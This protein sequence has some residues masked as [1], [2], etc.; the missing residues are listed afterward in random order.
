MKKL[1]FILSVLLIVGCMQKSPYSPHMLAIEQS[2]ESNADTALRQLD[3]WKDSMTTR[4]DSMLYVLV[5]SETARSAGMTF[6]DESWI[7]PAVGFFDSI[8]DRQRTARAMLM[9]ALCYYDEG[10]YDNAALWLMRTREQD[11]GGEPQLQQRLYIALGDLNDMTGRMEEKI[12]DYNTAYNAARTCGNNGTEIHALYKLAIAY[13]EK[14]A[15]DSLRMITSRMRETGGKSDEAQACAH[16]A[17]GMYAILNHD[18]TTALNELIRAQP[19]E[20]EC[21]AASLA[22]EIIEIR[23]NTEAARNMWLMASN[24][25]N[26]DIAINALTHL[27]DDNGIERSEAYTL[28]LSRL[29]NDLYADKPSAEVMSKVVEV[30]RQFDEKANEEQ[31]QHKITLLITLASILVL[32][33]IISAIAIV[34]RIRLK[35]RAKVSWNIERE[36]LD[37]TVSRH[38]HKIAA[39]GRSAQ[40]DDWTAL[41]DL[42]A[43]HDTALVGLLAKNKNLTETDKHLIQLIRLRFQP[44]EIAVLMQM[45]PQRVTNVRSRMLSRLFNS[46][47]GAKDFDR[48][49]R[50]L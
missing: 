17:A 46:K 35:R 14:R 1:P 28:S 12:K 41:N 3:E 32:A 19:Y 33:V 49:I 13:Y 47:G 25:N 43:N 34:Y 38:L 37:S 9:L 26:S 15:S 30:Q 27:L 8:G 10:Q 18:T 48:R 11:I 50:E 6:T 2:A 36:L 23:G 45:S 40:P 5:Y 29:L 16:T 21:R 44:S 20:P 7:E 4:A 24:S 39:T 42:T 22:A 31:S